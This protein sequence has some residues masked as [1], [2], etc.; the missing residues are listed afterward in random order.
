MGSARRNGACPPSRRIVPKPSPV[1]VNSGPRSRIV[2]G[3]ITNP[4]GEV[5]A[6]KSTSTQF[7]SLNSRTST[8]APAPGFTTVAVAP[9]TVKLS[10]S[11]RLAM[12]DTTLPLAM[13]VSAFLN[14]PLMNCTSATPRGKLKF[15][16]VMK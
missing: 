8:L 6:T 4:P 10:V 3:S 16:C 2:A 14:A 9:F 1:S 7:R 12:P 11:A 15:A 5:G 13:V